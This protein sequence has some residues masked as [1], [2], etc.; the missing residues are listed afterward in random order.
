M[1]GAA[2][3]GIQP[4]SCGPTGAH[5]EGDAAALGPTPPT[6]WLVHIVCCALGTAMCI[7]GL[8][9]TGIADGTWGWA[10]GLADVHTIISI[11]VCT[12]LPLFLSWHILFCYGV[13]FSKEC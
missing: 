7:E 13:S 5:R 3:A 10:G 6:P 1:F 8:L 4:Q 12:C 9:P 11:R 2:E